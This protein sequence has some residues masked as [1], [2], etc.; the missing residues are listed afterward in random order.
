MVF[1]DVAAV[2]NEVGRLPA[3]TPEVLP[4]SEWAAQQ[5]AQV[6]LGDKRLNRRALEMGAKMAAKPEASLPSQMESR[7]ALR[8]AYLV[9]NNPRVTLEAVL[10][11][12]IRQT[13]AAAGR[14]P[15]ALMVEDTTELDYTSYWG[16]SGLG[17]IGNGKGRGLLL[18]TT[19]AVEPEQR[20][21]LGVAH[22][23]V[24]LRQP[25]PAGHSS[26]RTGSPEGKVW[27]VSAENVGRPPEGVIWVHVGDAGSDIFEYMTACLDRGKHFLLRAHFNRRL[28]WDEDD[29]KAGADKAQQLLD[30]ARS[31]PAYPDS[32]Y[33]VQVPARGEQPAREACVVL[34]WAE[35]TIRPPKNGSPESR[36]RGPIKVW[37]LRVWE[38]IPPM[39]VEALEWVLLSSLP[40]TCLPKA[41]RATAWYSCRWLCEDYHQCLKTGCGVEHTQ[42]DDG[43]DIKRLLGFS[44]P[45]AARLLQLRQSARQTPD[46]PA[47]AVVEP[48]MV[49]VLARREK[50]DAQ[51]LTVLQFWREVARLGG[52]QGRRRD[53]PPGWQTIWK[54][55]RLL[56]DLTEGA[57]LFANGP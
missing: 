21:V 2:R 48:L 13:L 6:N 32:G 57:R 36:R 9:L 7:K 26:G 16:K 17:E 40:I 19:L 38:E 53:G 50:R 56:S 44:V 28:A 22:A 3:K 15:V 37:V 35:T 29:T 51:N 49:E 1:R 25:T 10:A 47:T 43:A 54:G 39:G 24:V 23:Q 27:E 18:H 4:A 55:W 34:A 11:P 33:T 42:L 45:I 12:H 5:W 52:H 41:T 14:V 8:G 20:Q 46:L 30:Y 31:L